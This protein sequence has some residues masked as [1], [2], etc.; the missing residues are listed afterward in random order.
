MRRIAILAK[1]WRFMLGRKKWWLV[2]L[3]FSLFLVGG[4]I[5]MA[6]VAT[7]LPFLYPLF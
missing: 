5:A 7:T 2:P 1:L 6:E 3:L 4:L